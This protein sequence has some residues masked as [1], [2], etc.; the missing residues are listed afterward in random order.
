[1]KADDRNDNDGWWA[2]AVILG[3]AVLLALWTVWGL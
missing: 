2:V 1:M 3:C